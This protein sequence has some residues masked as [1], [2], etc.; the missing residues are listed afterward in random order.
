MT[1]S[2]A[3]PGTSTASIF[4]NAGALPPPAPAAPGSPSAGPGGAA[5]GPGGPGGSGA[6]PTP[7]GAGAAPGIGQPG[8][9]AP[10]LRRP[11]N[12]RA[13]GAGNVYAAASD[14]YLYDL[15]QQ[16]GNAEARKPI[17]FLPPHSKVNSLNVSN[18]R[19]YA[20]TL[21]DCGGTPNAVYGVVVQSPN[22]AEPLPSGERK[23]ASFP[24]NG[25]GAS[26]TGV[27]V[28]IDGTVY[29][30]VAEGK[31]DVAGDYKDTVL[32]LDPEDLHVKDYFTPSASL[33]PMKKGTGSPGVTPMPFRWNGKTLV[34][35]ASR[36]G[37]LYLLDS[38]S[39]G[40]ADH[41]QPVFTS[42]PVCNPDAKFGGNGL[43]GNFSS[44]EDPATR[45]RWVYA[46]LW[47]SSNAESKFPATNGPA[48]T[49]SIV[50]F[51]VEDQ[52]G[53]PALVPQWISRNMIAPAPPV[54]G[55][56]L[57]FALSTGQPSRLTKANGSPYSAKEREKMATHAT[58]YIL[59]ATTGNE[60][61][62][63]GEAITGHT[64]GS[65]MALA[66]GRV[67]FATT[68]NTVYCYGIPLLLD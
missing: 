66:N 67:Y 20:A 2:L 21:D 8:P 5:A 1:A 33:P 45:I 13:R 59:D 51:K 6:P 34:L 11:S 61:F 48:S 44:W 35:A 53:K 32:A 30:Q 50:A 28:A 4:G 64:Q 25:T 36:D 40:G 55:N 60:L 43:W 23:V 58:L 31:G 63:S 24:T 52:N 54:T 65:G 9:A 18:G 56:G 19:L 68:D 29:V 3:L 7:G 10:A 62:T 22:P 26:G 47:G 37:R 14:G 15:R 17:P 12:Q 41:H 39:L 16:D 57:V 38:T 27:S 42:E 46:A 49:G